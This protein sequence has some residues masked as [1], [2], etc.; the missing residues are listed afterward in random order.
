MRSQPRSRP[1]FWL[2]YGISTALAVLL[3]ISGGRY[4][5]LPRLGCESV[6]TLLSG[7]L[8]V[9]SSIATPPRPA[10]KQRQRQASTTPHAPAG[11]AP[12]S[13]SRLPHPPVISME[14][15]LQKADLPLARHLR[16]ML[17]LSQAPPRLVTRWI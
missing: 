13:G 15:P 9:A 6:P 14:P 5:P 16:G 12:S 10:S 8:A 4:A 1:H 3:L 11:M 17:P 2:S 7:A